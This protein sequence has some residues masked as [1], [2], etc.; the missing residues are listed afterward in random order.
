MILPNSSDLD[1]ND[2]QTEENLS[3]GIIMYISCMGIVLT[4]AVCSNLL[5]I[6]CVIR[7]PKLRTTT[8]IFICNL[9][10]SDILLATYVMPLKLHDIT[11]HHI[12]WYEGK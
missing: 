7:L 4:F 2:H 5:V 8:N 6:Y 10:V 9:S 11:H 1:H 3:I 12:D